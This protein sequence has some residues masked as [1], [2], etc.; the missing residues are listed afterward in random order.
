[1]T[2]PVL[3]RSRIMAC[4]GQSVPAPVPQHVGMHLEGHS[5]ARAYALDKPIDGVRSERPAAL[6]GK[7]VTAIGKLPA[8]LPQCPQLVAAERVNGWLAIL[9]APDM[10]RSRLA[11]FDLR[12]FQITCL[13]RPETVPKGFS[14]VR[15]TSWQHD[16]APPLPSAPGPSTRRPIP[17]FLAWILS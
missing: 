16:R 11:E 17:S 4:I 5:G 1:M 14:E 7:D 15:P 8:Q 12:P 10:Q 2:E 9:E 13:G 3:D 6:S